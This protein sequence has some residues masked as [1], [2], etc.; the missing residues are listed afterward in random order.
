[1]GGR[2]IYTTS[3]DASVPSPTPILTMHE[4]VQLGV[5]PVVLPLRAAQAPAPLNRQ[6]VAAQ[7]RREGPPPRC[8]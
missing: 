8:R 1:M 6:P 2:G 7:I 5:G 3:G 4:S